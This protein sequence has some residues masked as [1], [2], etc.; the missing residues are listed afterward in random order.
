MAPVARDELVGEAKRRLLHEDV[1]RPQ[2]G[3]EGAVDVGT[4]EESSPAA[5]DEAHGVAEEQAEEAHTFLAQGPQRIAGHRTQEADPAR[6]RP[7]GREALHGA[8]GGALAD[9]EVQVIGLGIVEEPGPQSSELVL[10]E[11]DRPPHPLAVLHRVILLG[12]L[13]QLGAVDPVAAVLPVEKAAQLAVLLIEEMA[14]R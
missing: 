14:N 2:P 11:G 9:E 6:E 10:A 3:P 1:A 5:F 8:V 4:P 13:R 12:H 7:K